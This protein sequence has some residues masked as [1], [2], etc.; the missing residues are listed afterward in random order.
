M[1]AGGDIKKTG[2][3]RGLIK[4][5]LYYLKFRKNQIIFVIVKRVEE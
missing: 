3:L 5:F 4:P 1:P 2:M